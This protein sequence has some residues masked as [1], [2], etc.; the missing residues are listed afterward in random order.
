MLQQYPVLEEFTN[1]EKENFHWGFET[2]PYV[3]VSYQSQIHLVEITRMAYSIAS[4]DPCP[5]T[6]SMRALGFSSAAE[7]MYFSPG[8]LHRPRLK[9]LQFELIKLSWQAAHCHCL[10][11][12]GQL[13]SISTKWKIK[14]IQYSI[15]LLLRESILLLRSS[16]LFI[17]MTYQVNRYYN[18]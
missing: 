14:N 6:L 16:L 7:E 13:I 15:H 18:L 8:A 3:R 4:I 12:F 17:G 11:D 5:L 10:R 1:V 9:L 2:F